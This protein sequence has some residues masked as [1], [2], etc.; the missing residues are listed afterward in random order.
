MKRLAVFDFDHT[1]IDDNSDTV[2]RDLLSPDKIPP[3]L[4]QLHRKDGWTSYMQGVFQLLYEHGFR[5]NDIQTAIDNIKP[6]YGM[7]E[8]ITSLKLE[9]NYDIIIISDSNTYFIDTWLNKYNLTKNID[10]VFTNPANFVNDILNIQ[11]YHLQ[12]ECKMSTKNL[13]KGRIMEEYIDAQKKDGVTYERVIYIGDGMNDLCPILRLQEGDL[14]CVRVNYKCAELINL[15]E[16]GQP[17]DSSGKCYKIKSE[18][19][20][21]KNGCDILSYVR[22]KFV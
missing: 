1:I 9:L 17:I 22:N 14:A 6:V 21:W 2:V 18:V 13:C 20:T 8:L 12:T 19:F 16:L 10:K 5:K 3:S 15:L 4:K 11:M 7:T